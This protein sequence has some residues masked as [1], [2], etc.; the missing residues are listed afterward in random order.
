MS[1]DAMKRRIERIEAKIL[2]PPLLHVIFIGDETRGA[3]FDA[4]RQ[5]RQ[6]D[7]VS[8]LD[9]EWDALRERFI[10]GDHDSE[11]IILRVC[12]AVRPL[13]ITRGK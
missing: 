6:R 8:L 7:P 10:S 11:F 2:P 13:K 4:Y 5:G 1:K 9:E 3:A 12:P